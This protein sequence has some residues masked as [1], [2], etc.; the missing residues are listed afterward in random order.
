MRRVLRELFR[1]QQDQLASLDMVVRVQQ[2]FDHKDYP[3]VKQEFQQLL[4]K[5]QRRTSQQPEGSPG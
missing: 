5:L 4:A 2:A 3:I 1:V